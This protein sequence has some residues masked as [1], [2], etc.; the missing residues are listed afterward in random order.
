M[1]LRDDGAKMKFWFGAA[2]VLYGT[3][4]SVTYIGGM[5]VLEEATNLIGLQIYTDEGNYL[6]EVGNVIVNMKLKQ[7][8][9]LF[10]AQANPDL[11]EEGRAVAVPFRWVQAIGDIIV[12]RHFPGR[13]TVDHAH[14]RSVSDL[15]S[16][17]VYGGTY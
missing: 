6:G 17:A 16:A 10:V 11:V 8:E 14:Q 1:P 4:A 13:I 9:A 12:L 7:V 15:Q 2:K 5:V 3:S